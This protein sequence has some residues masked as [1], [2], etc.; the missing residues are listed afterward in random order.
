MPVMKRLARILLVAALLNGAGAHWAAVQGA[1]WAGMLAARLPERGV[2][3]AVATTFSGA[4]P[5]GVCLVVDKAARP[6]AELSA[7]MPSAHFIA[8]SPPALAP[9]AVARSFSL[10]E[11]CSETGRSSRPQAPPPKAALLA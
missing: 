3:E 6:A 2:T 1:A 8:M 5:C 4:D 11:Q 10:P 9:A 7:A